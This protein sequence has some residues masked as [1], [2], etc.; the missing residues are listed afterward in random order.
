MPDAKID[1]TIP[2]LMSSF[3]GNIGQRCLS[4]AVLVPVDDA[5]EKVAPKFKEAASKL[6]LGYGL[7]EETE[8]GPLVT[9]RAKERVLEYIKKGVVDE[10][11]LT[12]DGRKVSIPEYP[13]GYFL[14]ASVFEEVNPDMTIAKEEIF[15]P[16][17]SV[18]RVETLDEAIEIANSTKYGKA[19]CIFTGSGRHARKF[20]REV[21]AGNVGMNIGITVPMAFFPFGGMKQSFLGTV[22][23]QIDCLDFFTDKRTVITKWW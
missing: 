11:K 6:K 3:F 10:A 21:A 9:R 16:V 20:R 4:G 23:G 1:R 17:A 2:S 7:D 13:R 18:I 19:A 12:L 22:H 15:G 14:G 8:M 5:Y